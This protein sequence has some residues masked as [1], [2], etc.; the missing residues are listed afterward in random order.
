MNDWPLWE[1]FVRSKG[2]LAH[3]HVG[4]VHAPDAELA[5]RHARDTYTRR[6]EGVSL[7]VVPSAEIVASVCTGSLILG[8]VGLL[9]GRQATTNWF[10]SGIQEALGADIITTY[11]NYGELDLWGADLSLTAFL[12]PEWTLGLTGSLVSDDYF[13]LPL[14]KGRT[15]STVVALNAPK[16]ARLLREIVIGGAAGALDG[17]VRPVHRPALRRLAVGRLGGDHQLDAVPLRDRRGNRNRRLDRGAHH[18][19][20]L[21]RGRCLSRV[22]P[23]AAAA[24]ARARARAC[25]PSRSS[26]DPGRSL[27]S[28]VHG[29]GAAPPRRRSPCR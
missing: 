8:A 1:V 2:G 6:Q 18:G 4:S 5:L 9:E 21:R 27:R 25:W 7:W 14:G 16:K 15:D 24:H 26:T 3:R 23:R 13:N 28:R 19:C 29:C 10:Y 11:V 17:Q 22:R 12:N 20:G